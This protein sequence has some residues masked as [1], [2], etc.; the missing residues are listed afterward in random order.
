MAD[1]INIEEVRLKFVDELRYAM[2]CENLRPKDISDY[3]RISQN[4]FSNYLQ[5]KSLPNLWVM[6]LISDLL[7]CTVNELLDYDEADEDELVGYDPFATFEDEEEFTYHVR[8]R[9]EQYMVHSGNGVKELSEKTGF[10][11][12]TIRRW[13]GMSKNGPELPRTSDFLVICD[14]LGTTPSDLLGY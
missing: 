1:L 8:N 6:V 11:P 12:R 7:E 13:L 5:G 14:A 4:N 2:D 9:L 10:N 3:C